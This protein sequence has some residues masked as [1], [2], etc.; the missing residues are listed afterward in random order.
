MFNINNSIRRG[1]VIKLIKNKDNSTPWS[2]NYY[3]R[4][5]STLFTI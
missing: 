2:A 3:A 1:D 4:L 5:P